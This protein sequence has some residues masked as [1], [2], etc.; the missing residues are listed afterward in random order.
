MKTPSHEWAFRT[1]FRTN[2]FGWRGSKLA[3]ERLREAVGE[4]KA[5]A[6][7]TPEAEVLDRVEATRGLI[8]ALAQGTPTPMRS[9][10][11]GWPTGLR[12]SRAAEC[13]P[14]PARP[15]HEL[16]PHRRWPH[17]CERLLSAPRTCL[18]ARSRLSANGV[19]LP[20]SRRW[21]TDSNGGARRRPIVPDSPWWVL[22]PST[23]RTSA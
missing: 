10:A 2:A 15:R 3:I 17:Q 8:R 4:V 12:M 21:T 7:T 20:L 22:S 11:N 9:S 5:V 1:C 13:H 14:E 6:R 23:R 16:G 18:R 19:H